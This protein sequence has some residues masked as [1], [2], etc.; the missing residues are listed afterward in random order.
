MTAAKI[1]LRISSER[2]RIFPAECGIGEKKSDHDHA[3]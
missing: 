2:L 3:D 1:P